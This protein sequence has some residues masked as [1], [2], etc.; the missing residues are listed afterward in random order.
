MTP[1]DLITLALRTSGI[2]GVGQSANSDD[3]SDALAMLNM[4]TAQWAQRRWLVFREYDLAATCTGAGSYSIGPGGTFNTARPDRIDAAFIR[5]ATGAYSVDYDLEIIEAREDWN[6]IPVKSMPGFPL[7]M[8][9]DPQFPLGVVNLYPV[10]S[11]AYELHLTLKQTLGT[12]T[13]LD[14][15]LGMPDE[16]NEALLYNLSLRL[17]PAYQITVTPEI[18]A[19]AAAALNT[20]RAS[21]AQIPRLRMPSDLPGVNQGS[22]SSGIGGVF[23]T[24]P[25][26]PPG[27]VLDGIG[28]LAPGA[29]GSGLLDTVGASLG[30]VLGSFVLGTTYLA[31]VPAPIHVIAPPVMTGVLGQLTLGSIHLG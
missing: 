10:P 24:V 5:T 1:R 15:P 25:F 30:N 19:L 21:N 23:A 18:R 8:F 6:R 14:E 31:G 26:F 3:M 12:F 9:Y 29:E 28:T 22:Y 16:Y 17:A 7:V 27:S 11:G 2:T 20:I 4:M 13:S